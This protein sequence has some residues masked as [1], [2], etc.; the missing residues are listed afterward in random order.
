MARKVQP[1]ATIFRRKRR[2]RTP[3]PV[4]RIASGQHEFIDFLMTF[5]YSRAFSD[6]QRKAVNMRSTK[7]SPLSLAPMKMRKSRLRDD[8]Y[9]RLREL[10]MNGDIS[11]G[12]LI[13]IQTLAEAFGVS[14]MPIREAL[15]RLVA[16]QALVTVAG[17]SVEIP[18][19]TPERFIDL[20]RVRLLVEGT[21]A[22][23]AVDGA[24]DAAIERL[25]QIERDIEEAI[26]RQDAKSFVKLNR[27]FHAT[28]YKL[29][30]SESAY[31]IIE[32]FWLQVIPYHHQYWPNRHI[33]AGNNHKN[34]IEALKERDKQGVGDGIRADIQIGSQYLLDEAKLFVQTAS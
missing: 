6:E 9:Q 13:T 8:V 11:A 29:S 20:T 19:L 16:E 12:Q 23:W 21:V 27:E 33:K 10:I 15:L 14:M 32:K 22:E 7:A 5:V 2:C 1:P 17:G 30:N 24:S 25:E 31:S 34:V 4:S 26:G 28:L 18:R 3:A